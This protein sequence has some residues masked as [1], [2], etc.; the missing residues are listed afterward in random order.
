[1]LMGIKKPWDDYPKMRTSDQEL[2]FQVASNLLNVRAEDWKIENDSAYV[3][4]TF[5]T[6]SKS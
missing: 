3:L 6:R 2:I 5:Y 1:M 4:V